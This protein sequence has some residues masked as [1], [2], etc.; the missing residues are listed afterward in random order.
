MRLRDG[1]SA[2]RGRRPRGRHR[3]RSD[4]DD[5]S[6]SRTQTRCRASLAAAAAAAV[7]LVSPL[8]LVLALTGDEIGLT[9]TGRSRMS[10]LSRS[11]LRLLPARRGKL[12]RTHSARAGLGWPRARSP[13]RLPALILGLSAAAGFLV[14]LDPTAS[15]GGLGLPMP[16]GL[17]H[18]VV[19]T[20]A[21]SAARRSSSRCASRA[22]PGSRSDRLSKCRPRR[23]P[24]AGG[25]PLRA[26]DRR[27]R[28][29]APG[30]GRRP[31]AA[32]PGRGPALAERREPLRNTALEFDNYRLGPYLFRQLR[33]GR[34]LLN[35]SVE[36]TV[37]ADLSWRPQALRAPS[38][39]AALTLARV[40]E[41]VVHRTRSSLGG[42]R[43][44]F[45][46]PYPDGMRLY[47][48]LDPTP[49]PAVARLRTRT[50]PSPG[51]TE[52]LP[53]VEAG[54][55]E[56]RR[57]SSRVPSGPPGDVR[58]SR[59]GRPAALSVG[60]EASDDLHRSDPRPFLPNVPG[61]ERVRRCRS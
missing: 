19:P 50:T 23:G 54:G 25:R 2:A 46:A 17:I 49:Q 58:R 8:L 37:S 1:L 57:G 15:V 40:R 4:R 48:G 30:S 20:G 14:S 36:D 47:V 41:V 7:V 59:P 35:G 45:D 11:H 28:Q 22:S 42:R 16:A 34:P 61:P 60:E 43:F 21:C 52:A 53:V 55:R 39:R 26:R 33:H 10:P 44:G 32:R 27:H 56:A 5:A 6:P 9:S 31:R 18:E 38:A 24:A 51:L 29:E 13:R 12:R 3:R